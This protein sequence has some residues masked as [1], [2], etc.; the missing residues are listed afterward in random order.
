MRVNVKALH[1]R[2]LQGSG[3]AGGGVSTALVRA[4]VNGHLEVRVVE[5]PLSQTDSSKKLPPGCLSTSLHPQV[6]M[7]LLAANAYAHVT[8]CKSTLSTNYYQA[9]LP[10]ACT[11]RW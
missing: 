1:S 5:R 4:S 3:G 2:S 9:A 11:R 8:F 10:H 6:I 7:C